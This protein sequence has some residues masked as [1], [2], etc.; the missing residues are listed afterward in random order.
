MTRPAILIVEDQSALRAALCDF[1]GAAFPEAT[2]HG[3]SDGVEAAARCAA[4]QP[5]VVLM[6]VQLPDCSGIE[7]TERLKAEFRRIRVI[8]MS[9]R[10]NGTYVER[11]LAAGACAFIPKDRLDSQ[12][13]AAVAL[14]LSAPR[15]ACR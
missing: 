13:V 8:V 2:I 7:L 15:A 1:L 6:D 4:V 12:L 14:A 9:Y 11:A 5:D 3:A 10:S